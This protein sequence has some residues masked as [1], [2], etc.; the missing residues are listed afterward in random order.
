M[1]KGELLNFQGL[2]DIL[3]GGFKLVFSPLIGEIIQSDQQIL[4]MG[5]FNHQLVHVYEGK[6]GS[7][8]EP[9]LEVFVWLDPRGHKR[10]CWRFETGH[11]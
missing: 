1:F 3:G 11:V 6:P 5:W 10:C 4:Q 9:L 2:N 8:F 7:L